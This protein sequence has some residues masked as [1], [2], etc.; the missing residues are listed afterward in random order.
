MLRDTVRAVLAAAVLWPILD[1]A[2]PPP[3]WQ[4]PPPPVAAWQPPPPAWQPPRGPVRRAG[5]AVL[6]VA[7]RLATRWLPSLGGNF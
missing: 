6:D 1:R 3:A 5:A 4:P 2:P 7:D